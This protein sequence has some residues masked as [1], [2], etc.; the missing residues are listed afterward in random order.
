MEP[1]WNNFTLFGGQLI[2]PDVFNTWNTKRAL[3]F[4][5][6]VKDKPEDHGITGEDHING[7]QDTYNNFV[8][9]L[10]SKSIRE[11]IEVRCHGAL[12]LIQDFDSAIAYIFSVQAVLAGDATSEGDFV[13]SL[14]VLCKILKLLTA[15]VT[16]RLPLTA[17]LLLRK[18]KGSDKIEGFFGSSLRG[19]D[20]KAQLTALRGAMLREAYQM[21]LVDEAEKQPYGSC[22]ETIPFICILGHDNGNPKFT[23]SING[24]A[25]TVDQARKLPRLDW[26]E[27]CRIDIFKVECKRC[28]NL[29]SL[30]GQDT[31]EYNCFPEALVARTRAS[32]P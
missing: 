26:T 2:G 15:H 32:S 14:L 21:N 16:G 11:P 23:S 18:K 3:D 12:Q 17:C 10:R 24:F 28:L 25:M 13:P 5:R 7:V 4:L 31:N 20:D 9:R 19:G 29:L 1:D 6:D 27:F 30:G 22:A 8:E